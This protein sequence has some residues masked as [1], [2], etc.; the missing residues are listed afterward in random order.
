MQANAYP[1]AAGGK[2]DNVC[3]WNAFQMAH[4][5][6]CVKIESFFGPKINLARADDRQECHFRELSASQKK[7]QNSLCHLTRYAR[8]GAQRCTFPNLYGA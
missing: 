2:A 1:R 5:R 4:V 3:A 8:G 6:T 7:N